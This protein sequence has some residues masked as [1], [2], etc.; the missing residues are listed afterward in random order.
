MKLIFVPTLYSLA[1]FTQLSLAQD[2][3]ELFSQYIGA[4]T[5]SAAFDG[6][7]ASDQSFTFTICTNYIHGLLNPTKAGLPTSAIPQLEQVQ[8]DGVCEICTSISQSRVDSCCAVASSVNCFEQFAAQKTPAA[9][10]ATAT[11]NLATAT[12]VAGTAAAT[13]KGS[14]GNKVDVVSSKKAVSS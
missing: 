4:P 10:L 13:T 11:T 2:N 5:A 7:S 1:V 12:G 8:V 9:N 14:S 6:P 3:S